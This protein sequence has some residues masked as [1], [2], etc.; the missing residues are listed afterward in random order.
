MPIRREMA[1]TG[2]AQRQ[3]GIPDRDIGWGRRILCDCRTAPASH[4]PA[5]DRLCARPARFAASFLGYRSTAVVRDY[6]ATLTKVRMPPST[7]ITPERRQAIVQREV[8]AIILGLAFGAVLIVESVGSSPVGV[9]IAALFVVL[10]ACRAW[11][12]PTRIRRSL[13]PPPVRL[14]PGVFR[15]PES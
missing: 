1:R 6:G 13:P 7:P 5:R 9:A 10:V 14:K 3:R 12:L 4:L 11:R 2:S 15:E 8:V